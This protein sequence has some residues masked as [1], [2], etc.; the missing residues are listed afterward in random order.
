MSGRGQ[1]VSLSSESNKLISITLPGQL[2]V[3]G[4]DI[5]PHWARM[6]FSFS[7]AGVVVY[8]TAKTE[9]ADDPPTFRLMRSSD[10]GASFEEVGT[11]SLSTGVHYE[12]VIVEWAIESL[13]EGDFLRLDLTQTDDGSCSGVQIDIY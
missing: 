10:S 4:D 13:A 7:L 6:P 9:A 12:S 8:I 2:G 1:A 3:V 11:F 5:L